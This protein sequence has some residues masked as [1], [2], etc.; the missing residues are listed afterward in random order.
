MHEDRETDM[1][2]LGMLALVALLTGLLLVFTVHSI[3]IAIASAVISIII[4]VLGYLVVVMVQL[5]QLF[6]E[7]LEVDSDSL[8]L[9][10]DSAAMLESCKL[11]Q[12]AH[13]KQWV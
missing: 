6:W 11:A 9:Q 8:I 1:K 7:S 12:R 10:Q 13:S 4:F 3:P 5:F 2:L